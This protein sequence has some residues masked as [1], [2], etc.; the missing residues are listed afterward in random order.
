MTCPNTKCRF[1]SACPYSDNPAWC[2]I[3]REWHFKQQMERL[4]NGGG[5]SNP[6]NKEVSQGIGHNS[7]NRKPC[8]LID[9]MCWQDCPSRIMGTKENVGCIKEKGGKENG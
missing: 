2:Q 4:Q 6:V 3:L 9:E 8:T 7:P 1:L 5:N